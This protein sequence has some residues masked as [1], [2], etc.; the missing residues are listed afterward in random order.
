MKKRS[1]NMLIV[2]LL[3]LGLFA[4]VLIVFLEDTHDN[5]EENIVISQDGVTEEVLKFE[6]LRLVPTQKTEYTVNLVCAASGKYHISLDYAEKTNGGMR[7]FIKVLIKYGDNVAYS[8]GLNDLLLGSVVEFDGEL[9]ADD[10]LPITINYAM[11]EEVGNE[12]QGTFED[13]IICLKIE[14]I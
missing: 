1:I 6:N 10:P 3:L 8:G 5:F 2:G 4:V 7:D 13:F 14:K 11:P 12:A 9:Y